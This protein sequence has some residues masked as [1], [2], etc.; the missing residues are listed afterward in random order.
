MKHNLWYDSSNELVFLEFT[1]DY[2]L[3]DVEPIK[4]KI[5]ELLDG[6]PYRQLIIRMSD[7]A[8]VE[9]R[10]TREKSNQALKE[11][12]V[13]DVAFV[14]GNAANRMIAKVLLKTGAI[15]TQG[16]FFKTTE[17]AVNWL[18]RRR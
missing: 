10:E 4:A 16:D 7:I 13:T 17:D 5:Q 2:L 9:N 11:A 14:G 3:D 15:K 6:K 18:K 1:S 12:G 8:K